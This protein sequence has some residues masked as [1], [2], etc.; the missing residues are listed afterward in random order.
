MNRT[1]RLLRIL[2]STKSRQV[3]DDRTFASK[4][5]FH[6]RRQSMFQMD[7]ER[8]RDKL[9]DAL[10]FI[11][12]SVGILFGLFQAF[13]RPTTLPQ[14]IIPVGLLAW[15]LPFYYG[16]VRGAVRDSVADRYR[17]WIFLVL[18]SSLYAIIIA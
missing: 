13:L 12:G 18:G 2:P 8:R 4:D 15:V 6:P 10:L 9:D 14:F 16:Y 11:M 17:G 1:R 5:L 7:E 3:P